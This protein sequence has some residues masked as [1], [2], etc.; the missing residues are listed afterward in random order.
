MNG[1]LAVASLTVREAV[2]RR[3]IGAFALITIGLVALGV[4]IRPAQP[5]GVAHLWRTASL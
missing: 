4:G 1:V 2:R 5:L 3:L